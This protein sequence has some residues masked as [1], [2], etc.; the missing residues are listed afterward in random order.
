LP[1]IN[2]LR[3]QSKLPIAGVA[4]LTGTVSGKGGEDDLGSVKE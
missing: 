4:T 3:E 1:L 2:S